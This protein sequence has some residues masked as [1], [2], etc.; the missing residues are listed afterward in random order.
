M[1]TE[2][3][4]YA[5]AC[6]GTKGSRWT[7]SSVTEFKN[8][9]YASFVLPGLAA[10]APC[11]RG[12]VAKCWFEHPDKHEK[13]EATLVSPFALDEDKALDHQFNTWTDLLIP[14]AEALEKGNPESDDAVLFDVMR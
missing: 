6:T 3:K 1:E 4:V 11:D 5:R 2:V 10:K 8:Q 12:M 9:L 13:D 7:A 14:H